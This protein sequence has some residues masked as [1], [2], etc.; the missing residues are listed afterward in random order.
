MSFFVDTSCIIPA[1]CVWHV[2]HEQAAA[3]I[4]QRLGGGA[5]M[6][7]AAHALA[8]A[9]SVLTRFPP[10]FRLSPA[11]AHALL[12]GNFTADAR[13]IALSANGYR[14][15]LQRSAGQGIAGGR[16][17]DGV[18]AACALLA[19][20]TTFLTFNTDHFAGLAAEGIELI[21]PS[22]SS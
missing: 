7:T 17:Y 13:I 11:D 9:Y 19:K 2:H 6:T 21:D 16:I 1:V 12:E 20:A 3:E 4:E 14:Q 22:R 10:P 8:E 5:T 15:L 18:I